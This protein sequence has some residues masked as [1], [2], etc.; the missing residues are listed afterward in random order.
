MKQVRASEGKLIPLLVSEPTPQ[1]PDV[2]S[3]RQLGVTVDEGAMGYSHILAAPPNL[4]EELQKAWSDVFAKVAQDSEWKAQMEK[5]GYP[6]APL[7]GAD[8]KA[9]VRSTLEACERNK[10]AAQYVK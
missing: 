8:L 6:P 10:D 3:A 7:A 2:P 1:V 4:P 5:A 9:A